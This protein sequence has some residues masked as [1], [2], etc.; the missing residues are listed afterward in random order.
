MRRSSRF[1]PYEGAPHGLII[2]HADRLNGDL[3]DFI[4]A[5]P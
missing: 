2:T 5:G 4:Q 1:K 3:I